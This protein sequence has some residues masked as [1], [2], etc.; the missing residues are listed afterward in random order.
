MPLQ[1]REDKKPAN[2]GD[3]CLENKL[4]NDGL[5]NETN[6]GSGIGDKLQLECTSLL[7]MHIYDS[8]VDVPQ[9]STFYH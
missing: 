5:A 3:I 7:S 9:G 8:L 2:N 6:G 4:E 1:I